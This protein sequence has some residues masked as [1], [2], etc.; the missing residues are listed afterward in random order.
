MIGASSCSVCTNSVSNPDRTECICAVGYASKLVDG[1][2]QCVACPTG[3][4]CT[5]AGTL[6]TSMATA[7]GYWGSPDTSKFVCL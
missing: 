3:A 4:V 6:W 1:L 7:T 2:M 5:S